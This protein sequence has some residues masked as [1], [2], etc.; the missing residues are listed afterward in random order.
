MTKPLRCAYAL[1]LVCKTRLSAAMQISSLPPYMSK[2]T[3]LLM[4][5]NTT[6]NTTPF[7]MG[8]CTQMHQTAHKPMPAPGA[9]CS[10]TSSLLGRC[11]FLLS[12]KH[13]GCSVNHNGPT[14]QHSKYNLWVWQKR[15][16]SSTDNCMPLRIATYVFSL[17]FVGVSRCFPCIDLVIS[18]RCVGR[19]GC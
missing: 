14:A 19:W 1:V 12:T 18:A 16:D 2:Q 9:P 10:M 5:S 15:G 6:V 11:W 7:T 3:Q 4:T 13:L 8:R 17:P